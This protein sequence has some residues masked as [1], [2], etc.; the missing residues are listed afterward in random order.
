VRNA[1]LLRKGTTLRGRTDWPRHFSL[2]AALAVLEN[3]LVSDAGG[4]IKEQVDVLAKGSGFSFT[5]IA[6]IV[7]ECVLLTQLQIRMKMRWLCKNY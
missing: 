4:L 2:S 6:Q 5:D 3:S 7:P 1:V